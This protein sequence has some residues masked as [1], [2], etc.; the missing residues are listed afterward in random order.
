M[1]ETTDGRT[2]TDAG[3][4]AIKEQVRAFITDEVTF[5]SPDVRVQDD[6]PLLSGVLDSLAL[7]ELVAFIEREYGVEV[8]DADMTMDHFKDVEAIAAYVEGKR[9]PGTPVNRTA[10]AGGP[11]TEDDDMTIDSTTV[12]RKDEDGDWH[13]LQAVHCPHC[14]CTYHQAADDPT[15]VWDPGKAWDEGCT[16]RECHCHAEPVIGSRRASQPA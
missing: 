15:I 1:M 8:D 2:S 16:D 9:R 14:D 10:E 4:Q 13:D 5:D 6:S 12:R 3:R 7:M 11:R